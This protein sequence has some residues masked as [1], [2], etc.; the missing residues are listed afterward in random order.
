M[1]QRTDSNDYFYHVFLRVDFMD[2]SLVPSHRAL[3]L[4]GR[5]YAFLALS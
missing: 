3:R 4:D 5:F 2:M 1:N